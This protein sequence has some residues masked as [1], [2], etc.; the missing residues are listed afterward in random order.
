MWCPVKNGKSLVSGAALGAQP[1]DSLGFGWWL[2]NTFHSLLSRLSRLCFLFPLHLFVGYRLA[3]A[4]LWAPFLPLSS[5]TPTPSCRL[6]F[7]LLMILNGLSFIPSFGP[8]YTPS[9]YF[10]ICV[11]FSDLHTPFRLLSDSG[12][13]SQQSPGFPSFLVWPMAP[14]M[15]VL[16]KL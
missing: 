11:L 13:P 6:C 5:G 4:C 8:T 1:L 2:F 14:V 10:V 7:F 15:I 12:A 16:M 9:P 3:M